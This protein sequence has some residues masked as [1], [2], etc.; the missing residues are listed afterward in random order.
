MKVLMTGATGFIGQ[1]LLSFLAGKAEFDVSIATRDKSGLNPKE[2][3][4]GDIDANTDWSKALAG[5]EVVVHLA[6]LAHERSRTL[7]DLV[8]VNVE[9]AKNLAQQAAKLGVSRFIFVSSIGVNGSSAI[10]PINE[11]SPPKPDNDYAFSKLLAEEALWEVG[12]ETGLEIVVI[13]PPLT[14]GAGARGR[15]HKLVRLLKMGVPMPFGAINNQRSFISIYNLIDFITCCLRHPRAAN[16]IFMVSDGQDLSISEFIIKVCHQHG[17][18]CKTLDAP[19]VVLNLVFNLLDKTGIKVN[20]IES[21]QVDI[22]KARG[23]LGWE[24]SLATDK[25]LC[26]N[27]STADKRVKN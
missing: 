24:P 25:A 5:Q 4:V 1:H 23:V 18:R 2:F 13:R 26:L 6:G 17:L 3:I 8:V 7:K 12:R 19:I 20:L 22:S 10:H 27:H 9:G 11:N 14:Y 16:E 15:F 21:F